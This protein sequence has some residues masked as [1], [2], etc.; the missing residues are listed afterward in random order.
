MTPLLWD[1]CEQAD[2]NAPE[3]DGIRVVVAVVLIIAVAVILISGG[4]A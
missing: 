4:T 3:P 1:A 2:H